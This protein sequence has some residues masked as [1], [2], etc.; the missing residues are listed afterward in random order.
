MDTARVGE[1][2]ATPAGAPAEFGP[3]LRAAVSP[4]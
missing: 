3:V 1:L 4:N 2:W